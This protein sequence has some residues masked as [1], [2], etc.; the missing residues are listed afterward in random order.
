MYTYECPSTKPYHNILQEHANHQAGPL[1]LLTQQQKLHHMMLLV[2]DMSAR[3]HL[4]AGKTIVSL[5]PRS[6]AAA[7][8]VA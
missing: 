4:V 2:L 8:L 3:M 7:I 5:T 1:K 6:R